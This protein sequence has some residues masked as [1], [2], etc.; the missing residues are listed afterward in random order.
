MINV[1]VELS[2]Y[3]ILTL[4]VIYTFHCFYLVKQQS[5]EERN[6]S[7]RQQLMLIFF[8]DFTAFLVIYLKTGKFQVVL[9]YIEMMAFFAGIQILYRIFYKKAS[10]LL[11]NN[12]CMLLSVGFIMLCRLDVSTA[13]RQLVIVAGVN[14]VALIVPVLIRKMKFL[15]DLTWVY[16]GIGIVLLAAVFVLAKTSY[17]AKLSLMGIQPSEAIKITFVFFMAALLRKGA[18]FSKVV[19]ATVVAGLHVGI[20]V[21]SVQPPRQSHTAIPQHRQPSTFQRPWKCSDLLC[22]ISCDDLC[23]IQKCGISGTWSCRRICRGSCRISSVWPCA[24]ESDSL[25]GSHGGIS[26]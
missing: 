2:K 25:E 12:M 24:S 5:E 9:F 14:V 20:L 19:Q 11:L 1:I 18:D 23:G 22:G 17:G 21:R 15:K 3:V 4:M 13:T 7:L 6:E 8:M 10:I 16:A 26:E